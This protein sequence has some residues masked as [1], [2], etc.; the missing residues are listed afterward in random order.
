MTPNQFVE[1]NRHYKQTL[2]PIPENLTTTVDKA[3][4]I[5]NSKFGYIELLKNFDVNTWIDEARQAEPYYVHHRE[6][7]NHMGWD[8]CCIHGLG[9]D[10]TGVWQHYSETEPE[11][12]WTE[13]S[14]LTPTIKQ[15]WLSMP[16]EKLLRV[17]FMRVGPRGYVYPH[18]D[19]PPNIDLSNIDLLNHIVPINI[20]ITHPEYCVMALKDYGIVPWIGG[21]VKLVNITNDHCV[22]NNSVYNRVHMIGH[23]I[24]G[25]KLDEFSELLVKSY[26][27]T[28]I[29]KP[30]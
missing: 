3:R 7:D 25:N 16:F 24:I 29:Y 14:E 8:S 6:G 26:E 2:N 9:T 30:W 1:Q 21:D 18:N 20:A 4:Y 28:R 19:S 23:G 15:F 11:Y 12:N 22:V 27:H 5:A 17:R 10:K 13:L